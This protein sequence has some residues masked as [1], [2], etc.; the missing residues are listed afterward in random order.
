[1]T[2]FVVNA[3]GTHAVL[4]REGPPYREWLHPVLD[5]NGN[6][7]ITKEPLPTGLMIGAGATGAKF[8]HVVSDACG[9]APTCSGDTAKL[10]PS[11]ALTLWAT[12]FFGLEVGYMQPGDLGISG[13]N[14]SLTFSSVFQS[15]I[16]PGALKLG[17]QA[18]PVR[19]F[20]NGGVD[21]AVTEQTTTQSVGASTKGQGGSQTFA[22]KTKGIG[23]YFG[24]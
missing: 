4:M 14:T 22:L 12:N 20:A 23:L 2:A 17:A 3:T 19:L 21:Y 10:A 9:D 13:T 5:E 1:D 16:A 24:G 7:K 8:G 18:G 6:V 15:R 11:A